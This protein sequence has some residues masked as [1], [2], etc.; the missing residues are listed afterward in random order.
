MSYPQYPPQQQ[1]AYPQPGQQPAY[2][3]QQQQYP[4]QQPAYGQ[5]PYGQ[6]PYGQQQ[7]YPPQAQPSPYGGYQQQP[8]P[9][10]AYPPQQQ[11]QQQQQQQG[12]PMQNDPGKAYQ[13][14]PPV[15]P[16]G[17]DSGMASGD[18]VY[19]AP[20]NAPA[21]FS[22]PSG[23][24]DLWAAVLWLVQ[25]GGFVALAAI[26][27]SKVNLATMTLKSAPA[28]A[29]PTPTRARATP[30]PTRVSGSSSMNS[31]DLDIDT[32]A[33]TAMVVSAVAGGALSICYLLAMRRFPKK[34][35]T[36]TFW[37][38][39]A[40]FIALGIFSFLFTR[41]IWTGIVC[42]VI[43]VLY[44]MVWRSYK[45]RIPF[46]SVMLSTVADVTSK[47]SGTVF[48]ALLGLIFQLAYVVFWAV[49]VLTCSIYFGKF[50]DNSSMTT[51]RTVNGRT[52]TTT[53]NSM[54]PLMYPLF[55]FLLFSYYW[56]AQVLK[57][58]VHVTVSGVFAS[59]FFL[60]GSPQGMPSSPTFG[61]WKRAVT[62]SFGSICFGSLIIALIQT[63]RAMLRNAQS[64]TDSPVGA[65]L[66]CCI[67]CLLAWIEGLVE[68]FNVYAFTQVAIYG[69]PFCRAAKDTWTM[70][71][72]RGVDAIINDDLIGNVL[73]FG[74][75][76]IG[77]ITLLIGWLVF[78]VGRA[79]DKSALTSGTTMSAGLI[80]VLVV[81]FLMGIVVFNLIAEVI[82][83]GVATIFVCIA[84]DPNA[85]R[86]T[87]PELWE[88][89]RRTYPEAA[90]VNM[91][92]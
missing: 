21:R 3:P 51:T 64:D 77:G 65:F 60:S 80:I 28:T 86:A 15:V 7:Q 37:L 36:V 81:S 62:T 54:P 38:S 41:A 27:M 75:L 63:V 16:P 44:M 1:G 24:Q 89:I 5:Q 61:A 25:L 26:S 10:P 85:L 12:F 84:E 50:N 71:K 52:T 58:I 14:A 57:N 18:P 56:T 40:Y 31:D 29:T 43:A 20:P 47:Y 70:I 87:K 33:I 66:L 68:Y 42:L 69:K 4:P 76:L 74:S 92:S 59:F 78:L 13:A 91:Y 88:E 83:S 22:P 6:Q 53:N 48:A 9:G 73:G 67:E 45:S 8:P 82:N 90:F 11:Q 79:A 30:T 49:A 72:D 19:T 23:P 35:I 17:Y 34:L 46:A 39:V 2:P 55:V 32:S